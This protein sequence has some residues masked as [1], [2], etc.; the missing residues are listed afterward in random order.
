MVRYYMH[1]VELAELQEDTQY[2]Y[3]VR[4]ANSAWSSV[5]SF[6][7]LSSTRPPVM[8]VFG[9]MGVYPWNNM[10]NLLQ[11]FDGRGEKSMQKS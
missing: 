9:D 8:A 4:S 10:A 3:R 5:F 2:F 1:F 6:R 11:V 7:T